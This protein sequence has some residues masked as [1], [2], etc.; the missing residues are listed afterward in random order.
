[1]TASL[2]IVILVQALY[3]RL[4][5]NSFAMMKTTT[6]FWFF[7]AGIII[8]AG[9]NFIMGIDTV[10]KLYNKDPLAKLALV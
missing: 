4:K 9:M 8:T 7:W 1:V 3:E 5:T 6:V 2:T 10:I